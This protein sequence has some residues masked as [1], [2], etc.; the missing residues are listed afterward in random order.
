MVDG[1]RRCKIKMGKAKVQTMLGRKEH[2]GTGSGPE[3]LGDM[4][5]V[6]ETW[7]MRGEVDKGGGGGIVGGA[8]GRDDK[9]RKE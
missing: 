3:M 6:R 2:R 1:T 5:R 7:K 4:M 9:T 8:A